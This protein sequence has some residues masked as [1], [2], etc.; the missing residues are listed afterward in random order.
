MQYV[1]HYI[2]ASLFVSFW[3]VYANA[4]VSA[5]PRPRPLKELLLREGSEPLDRPNCVWLGYSPDGNWLGIRHKL[6]DDRM[7]IRV[8]STKDW[9]TD[10]WDFDCFCDQGISTQ[11]CAFAPDSSRLYYVANRS[12]YSQSLPPKT[13][14]KVIKIPTTTDAKYLLQ[15]V[16]FGPDKDSCYVTTIENHELARVDKV[17]LAGEPKTTE[18]FSLKRTSIDAVTCAPDV[19]LVAV[20]SQYEN[21]ALKRDTG[22]LEVFE[23]AKGA[24][25]ARLDVGTN[26][27]RQV[28]FGPDNATICASD[29]EAKL[30]VWDSQSGRLLKSYAEDYTVHWMTHHPKRRLMAYCTFDRGEAANCKIVDNVT[31]RILSAINVDRYGSL[32]VEYSPDGKRLAT[33]GSEGIVRVWDFDELIP[34]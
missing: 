9:K 4:L 16:Q 29:S 14:R 8:W 3:L 23:L 26:R 1:R 19:T 7:R 24:K 18:L 13:I 15:S 34:K 6:S 10:S 32:F 20:V 5:D 17:S 30:Y 25:T 2:V 22:A 31:G 12:L 33:V 11:R 27:F 21:V 28:C